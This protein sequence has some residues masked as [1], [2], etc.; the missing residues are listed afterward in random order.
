MAKTNQGKL[1]YQNIQCVIVINRDL[2]K[3]QDTSGLL[4][5]LGLKTILS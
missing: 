2:L 3:K 5:S 1:I 4:S